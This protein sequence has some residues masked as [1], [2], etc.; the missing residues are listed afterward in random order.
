[1]AEHRAR[2]EDHSPVHQ[3]TMSPEI[4]S[5]KI[6]KHSKH[7]V[8][9]ALNQRKSKAELLSPVHSQNKKEI[10][11]LKKNHAR[12]AIGDFKE[13]YPSLDDPKSLQFMP[14]WK[15]LNNTYDN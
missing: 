13:V 6:Q 5:P 9:S 7:N 12:K 14:S 1:M 4:Q 11:H 15:N 3:M 8:L 10:Q 2:T